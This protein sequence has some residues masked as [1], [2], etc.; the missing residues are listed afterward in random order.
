MEDSSA[1]KG[2]RGRLAFW[3]LVVVVMMLVWRGWK[4]ASRWGGG[5]G[6]ER[7]ANAPACLLARATAYRD[8]VTGNVRVLSYG[9]GRPERRICASLLKDRLNVRLEVMSGGCIVS[10]AQRARWGT[11]NAAIAPT[12]ERRFGRATFAQLEKESSRR[13]EAERRARRRPTPSIRQ[14]G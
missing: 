14:P 10:A 6:L 5:S 4:D 8:I 9:G 11:Y 7:I 2:H 3:G 12:L 1:P 13:C